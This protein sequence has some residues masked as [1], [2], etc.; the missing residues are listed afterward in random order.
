MKRKVCEGMTLASLL[1]AGG[2]FHE[3][4]NAETPAA[5]ASADWTLVFE[6][7]FDRDD[8]GEHWHVHTG[9]WEIEN[10]EL[11]GHGRIVLT[12]DLVGEDPDAYLRLEFE[13]RTD[14]QP[15]ILPGVPAPEVEVCDL[16]AYIHI[17]SPDTAEGLSGASGYVFQFGGFNNTR[18]RIRRQGVDLAD[19]R[20]P[21]TLIV[22]DQVHRIVVENDAGQLR[23]IVD[24]EVLLEAHDERA[25]IGDGH[26]QVGFYFESNGRVLNVKVY[27]QNP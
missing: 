15:F 27:T 18:N 20:D 9:S 21:E 5:D 8:L 24:D 23:L 11:F 22:P 12:E 10:G 7:D 2:M 14:V 17:Q 26:D 1:L 19:D 16:S 6:D 25:I 13:A 3:I 4:G